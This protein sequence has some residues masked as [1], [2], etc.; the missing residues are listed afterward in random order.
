MGTGHKPD[1]LAKANTQKW[2]EEIPAIFAKKT[3]VI[4]ATN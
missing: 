2:P 1:K 3:S 4:L